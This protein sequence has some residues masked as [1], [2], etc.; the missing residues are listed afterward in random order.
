[1]YDLSGKRVL[2]IGLGVSGRAAVGLLLRCGATVR[3]VDAT[4]TPALRQQLAPLTARGAGIS[5][6]SMRCPDEPLD[7]AVISPGIATSIPLV[8]ELN[9]RAVPVIGELELAFRVSVCLH[10]AITGTNGKTTTTEMIERLLTQAGRQTVAAGNIGRAACEVADQ[11]RDLDF[12]TLEVSSFQLETIQYFRPSVAVL[13]NLTP[14]HLDRY[15]SMTDYIQAKARIFLNQQA[16]DWAIIQSEA[17]AQLRTLGIQIPAKVI[18]YSARNR[19]ADL[20]LERGL[21]VSQLPDWS[22]PLL[23]LDQCQVRGPHNAEN[24]MAALAVSRVLR[25]PLNPVIHA[26]KNFA[27]APHRCEPV[28]EIAGVRYINDSK[29]TNVDATARAVESIPAAPAG[30]PNI[31]LIAGGKDKGFE[32]HDIGPLLSRRVK[33]AFLLGETRENI[34]AAWSLFTPCHLVSSL[35]EA[36]RRAAAA[37]VAGDVVLLSPACSSFDMFRHYQHR[38]EV[39]REIVMELQAG[40]TDKQ[41]RAPYAQTGPPTKI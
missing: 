23:S 38:G 5:L 34:R 2:V 1:M 9:R 25:L 40:T 8:T 36:V 18:T 31:W 26:L 41:A 21:I 35:P 4:D 3:A 22:G 33:G 28:A 37:A 12:L 24:L 15:A 10:I 11:T 7:L 17:L 13:T 29:A 39:F 27:P 20:Y 14:D 30:E 32:Y 6:G 16:F 19:R